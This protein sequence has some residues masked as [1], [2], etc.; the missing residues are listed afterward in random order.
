M[1]DQLTIRP[2]ARLITMLG[3]QLIK[4]EAIALSELIKNSYDADANWVKVTFHGF[5]ANFET[6]PDS[7]IAIEDDGEGM[8][9]AVLKNHWLNPATPEKLRRKQKNPRT[10]KGRILQ[11]E[12][13]IGRFAVFKLGSKIDLVTRRISRSA[14]TLNDPPCAS[15]ENAPEPTAAGEGIERSLRYDFTMYDDDFLQKDGKD[16]ELFIDDLKVAY[17]EASP[18]ER[19]LAEPIKL[20]DR[21]ETRKPHGTLLTISALKGNWTQRRVDVV[22]ASIGSL[23]PIFADRNRRP[24]FEVFFYK[25]GDLFFSSNAGNEQFVNLLETK[26]TY[27]IT[28][29]HFHQADGRF[30]FKLNNRDESIDLHDSA[31]KGYSFVKSYGK[32]P[33]SLQCGDFGFEFY[34]FDL[35]RSNMGYENPDGSNY[36]AALSAKH[37]DKDQ[38][39][40]VREHRTYLYRDGVRVMPYGDK[41]DDWLGIDVFRGTVRASAFPSNDQLIGCI[42]ISQKDNPHL[43]DKTNR[44]GLLEDTA[45][46]QDFKTLVL[47]LLYWLQQHPFRDYLNAKKAKVELV[48]RERPL[49]L[50]EEAKKETSGNKELESIISEIEKRY[51]RERS[52]NETRIEQVENLAAVGISVETAAHDMNIML[53]RAIVQIRTL[54]EQA[55]NLEEFDRQALSEALALIIKELSFI[56]Q[57]MRDIQLLFPSSRL[58]K[59]SISVREALDKAA[60]IY[61]RVMTKTG[62]QYELQENGPEL[63]V[64]TTEAALLQVFINLFDN[65]AYWLETTRGQ[66]R[67]TVRI[68]GSDQ[69]VTFADSG[70]GVKQEDVP[71]VFEAFYSGKRGDPGRGLGLYISRQLLDRYGYTID[72]LTDPKQSILPG[73][74][75]T[76]DFSGGEND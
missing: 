29:G 9:E 33:L 2:F 72:V 50:I 18:P 51:K 12:K 48:E 55:E 25:D 52:V 44:E 10:P 76:I 60:R 45:D 17:E 20:G 62:I 71:Y 21:T 37:L 58:R 3:D 19:I 69:R 30:T 6:G 70:P 13:G 34:L 28:H 74:N 54:K 67:I 11:G 56:E 38:E 43:K 36:A 42:Y 65:A 23:L 24:D 27:R 39:R 68:D 40:L 63:I 32:D 31:I 53:R 61:Q 47:I 57:S 41:E 1:E 66:R 49:A 46:F 7:T 4:N 26:S 22:K 15:P 75:F 73:A 16:T 59:K 64:K 8:T 5:G 14:G 35:S